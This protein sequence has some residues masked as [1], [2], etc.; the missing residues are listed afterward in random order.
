IAAAAEAVRGLDPRRYDTYVRSRPK[1]AEDQ[2]IALL[3]ALARATR[4]R[5]HIVHLSSANAVGMIRDARD[6]GLAFSAETT[7]HYLHFA[8]EDIP[9]GATPFKC[10]PPIRERDNRERLWDGLGAGVVDL[11][12]SDHSPCT[13]ELKRL[14]AGDFEAAWGGIASLQLGLPVMW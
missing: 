1:A 10:A 4:A 14:E 7:P 12:V 8:A 5:V 13:P 11:V 2:A 6:E 9:D 3:V